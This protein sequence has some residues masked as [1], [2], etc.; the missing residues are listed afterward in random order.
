MEPVCV[1]QVPQS[2][3]IER[4]VYDIY[5]NKGYVYYNSRFGYDTNVKVNMAAVIVED[6]CRGT[7]SYW[8]QQNYYSGRT[9]C[10]IEMEF[11]EG[12]YPYFQ[13]FCEE[14]SRISYSKMKYD[15]VARG[16]YPSFEG[17][18]LAS[19]W[20]K[21]MPCS[22]SIEFSLPDNVLNFENVSIIILMMDAETNEILSADKLSIN[23]HITPKYITSIYPSTTSV[24]LLVG[25]RTDWIKITCVP[26][27]WSE[28]EM[29]FSC[30]DESLFSYYY[31]G[32][33]LMRITA[34]KDGNGF[35]T[36]SSLNHPNVKETIYVNIDKPEAGVESIN[37]DADVKVDVYSADG[38]IVS[39]SDKNLA[40]GLYIVRRGD[41]VTKMV[42]K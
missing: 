38:Y 16:I 18:Y 34:L 41:K 29:V 6:E 36:L 5:T 26:S 4:I 23:G 39:R 37:C 13:R 31:N 9:E 12:M 2:T 7:A 1:E 21:D 19:E 3:K 10:R 17:Q 15:N 22:G 8:G 14:E 32:Q 20:K 24:N 11:G 42:V 28:D 40:P 25:G 33:G 30:S 27:D 35:I